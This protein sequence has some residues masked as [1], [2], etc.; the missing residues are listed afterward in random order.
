M[1]TITNWSTDYPG[2]NSAIPKSAAL[3][4]EVLRENGYATAA[5]GKWHLIPERECTLSQMR[6]LCPKAGLMRE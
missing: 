5:F 4:S 2:Y 1:G 3:V 6:N